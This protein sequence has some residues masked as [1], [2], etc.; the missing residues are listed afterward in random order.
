MFAKKRTTHFKCNIYFYWTFNFV[1][2]I[3]I[4]IW[5]L[6]IVYNYAFG[7]FNMAL[8]FIKHDFHYFN[9]CAHN[10]LQKWHHHL[11]EHHAT[12]F[13]NRFFLCLERSSAIWGNLTPLS[14]QLSIRYSNKIWLI[15]LWR[16][17]NKSNN[18]IILKE[19]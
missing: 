15:F 19:L 4:Y 16:R 5:L 17:L 1:I 10:L 2:F 12:S 11:F 6:S 7:L 3:F 9:F 8:P 13:S 14:R 18:F